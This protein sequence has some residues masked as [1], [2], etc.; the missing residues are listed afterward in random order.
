MMN[1]FQQM[2][3]HMIVGIYV[4][5]LIW[6]DEEDKLQRLLKSEMGRFAH[7]ERDIDILLSMKRVSPTVLKVESTMDKLS[8]TDNGKSLFVKSPSVGSYNLKRIR[9][10]V[11]GVMCRLPTCEEKSST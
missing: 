8:T 5:I 9:Q 10:C 2:I 4:F 11:N 1:S 6:L 7:R 3:I